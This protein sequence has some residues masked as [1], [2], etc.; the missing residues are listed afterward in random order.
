[1][2]FSPRHRLSA[3][4][5]ARGRVLGQTRER[6]AT[7]GLRVHLLRPWYD[8]DTAD[9]LQRLRAELASRADGPRRTRRCLQ[10]FFRAG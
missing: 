3:P 6:A 4:K 1:M 5:L 7:R 2:S 10:A 8:V 9:D